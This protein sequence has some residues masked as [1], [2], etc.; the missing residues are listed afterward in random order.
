MESTGIYWQPVYEVLELAF[1][2]DMSLVV[3]NARHIRTLNGLLHYFAP[4]F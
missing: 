2:G 1:N 4:G 3:V